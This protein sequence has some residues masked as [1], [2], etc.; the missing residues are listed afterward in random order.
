MWLPGEDGGSDGTGH[1]YAIGDLD[2][3][4]CPTSSVEKMGFRFDIEKQEWR[5]QIV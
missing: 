3:D 2:D 5:L 4:G 1:V